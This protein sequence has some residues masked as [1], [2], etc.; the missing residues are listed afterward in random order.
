VRL[1]AH[2]YETIDETKKFQG[3]KN[4][5]SINAAG[6]AQAVQRLAH[7]EKR[8]THPFEKIPAKNRQQVY[9]P[10]FIL[11]VVLSAALTLLG[12]DLKEAKDE[13]GNLVSPQGILSFELIK[14][15][16]EASRMLRYWGES[17]KVSAAFN[18]GLDYLFIFAYS[19][20]IALGCVW[21]ACALRERR[22]LRLAA[23]GIFIAWLQ[24]LAGILDAIEN[25]A[26]IKILFHAPS[27]T[28]ALISRWCAMPKFAFTLGFGNAYIILGLLILGYWK[29]FSKPKQLVDA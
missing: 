1:A 7:G 3:R 5:A 12:K 22:F 29:F 4:K 28:L 13:Q 21:I 14:D 16:A 26:L 6:L 17:K 9:W 2:C 19:N 11:T 8:M 20:T 10:M 15:Q 25:A 24:W 18:L 23:A 27:D